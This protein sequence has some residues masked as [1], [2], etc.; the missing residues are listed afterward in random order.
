MIAR[1]L[2]LR[3]PFEFERVR[4]AGRSW[5]THLLVLAVLANE[6][7][8]NRYG[9]AVGRRVGGA[10]ERNRVKRRLREVVRALH[11]RLEQG[12]DVVLIARG[13]LA[14]EAIPFARLQQ[15]AE[16]LFRRAR[17][18]ASAPV[19]LEDEPGTTT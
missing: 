3:R 1:P 8:H 13:P 4:R 9:F 16:T 19:S 14:D 10:V 11:P 12:F 18:L 2:R 5:T 15:D 7:E 17:L 6:R